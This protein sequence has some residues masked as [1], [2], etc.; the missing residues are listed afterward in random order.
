ERGPQGERGTQGERG[1]QGEQG[2]Q[3][4]QG[5]L[6]TAAVTQKTWQ[7]V[8]MSGSTIVSTSPSQAPSGSCTDSCRVATGPIV[9]TQPSRIITSAQVKIRNIDF[10]SRTAACYLIRDAGGSFSDFTYWA[11]A[12]TGMLNPGEQQMLPMTGA[13][14]V[15]AGT[16][17]I[18][19]RCGDALGPGPTQV[20]EAD[21][22]TVTAF[23]IAS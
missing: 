8:T 12:T 13:A 11:N 5:V 16:Y 20:F 15:S 17:D 2:V 14:D 4:L 23:A 21:D 6:A 10:M 22:I 1:L 3:G 7:G 19:V 18:G 9:V